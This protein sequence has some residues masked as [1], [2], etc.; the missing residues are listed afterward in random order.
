[1]EDRASSTRP[2]ASRSSRTARS[3]SAGARRAP[4]RWNLEL[5]GVEPGADAPR[6]PRRARRGRR[7]PAS[8]SA[9][10]RAA[11]S[12]RRGVP[13]RR[14]GGRLVT[15][16]FDLLAAQLG[17]R[18]EGLPGD[19]PCRL[20]RRRRAVH[21]GL[22]GGDHRRRRSDRVTRVARE[23]A[24]NAERTNGRSMIVLGAGTNHWFHS[25]QIYRAMLQLVAALRL[26]GRQRRRLGPLRRPGEGAPDHRLVD[27]RVRP[28][29]DR[30]RRASRR[31]RRSGSSRATSSAT[32]ASRADEFSTPLGTGVLDG[33]HLADC[34]ALAARLGWMPSY[35]TFDRNP[36]DLARRG[37][38]RRASSRRAYVV[39]RAEERAAPLRRRGPRRAG[40]LPA[41]LDALARQPA[42]LLEQ[43]PRVLPPPRARRR[44]RRRP[45]RGGGARA[46]ARTRSSGA[47]RRRRAS[48]T[49]SRRSTSA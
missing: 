43:G 27:A 12:L 31:R 11:A 6:A 14:V 48:S 15:T 20:R 1:M 42:R 38:G 19:W 34:N 13:A 39:E 25:D 28:R 24:R 23:F 18:R 46:S 32:S 45:K 35:P 8:T 17:V 3:A 21:A 2:P 5:D 41:R 9:T 33:M 29:L 47:T 44:G 49:C 16:V 36:L 37:G 4:G 7:C 26:P 10:P 22:A 40:E 30:G